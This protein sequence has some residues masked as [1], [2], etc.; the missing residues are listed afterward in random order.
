MLWSLSSF[1]AHY[2]PLTKWKVLGS[3][4]NASHRPLYQSGVVQNQSFLGVRV[5]FWSWI[6][7]IHTLAPSRIL[8]YTLVLQCLADACCK[9]HAAWRWWGVPRTLQFEFYILRAA[10]AL[11]CA[12]FFCYQMI[13][14]ISILNDSNLSMARWTSCITLTSRYKVLSFADV[15]AFLLFG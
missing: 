8:L 10:H 15:Q 2:W 1:W 6:T 13:C 7:Q 4:A 3:A 5:Y 12:R 11:G 14:R 9:V